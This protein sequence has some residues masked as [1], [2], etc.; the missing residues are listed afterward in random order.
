VRGLFFIRVRISSRSSVTLHNVKAAITDVV[1]TDNDFV[2]I[3]DPS[4]TLIEDV[5]DDIQLFTKERFKESLVGGPEYARPF[6][7]DA[8]TTKY[9][10]IAQ[11][12]C[13]MGVPTFLHMHDTQ[14]IKITA[15]EGV[16]FNCRLSGAGPRIN[17]TVLYQ[18]M[19]KER[20]R[21]SL[22]DRTGIVIAI[23]EGLG[24]ELR[25]AS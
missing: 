24:N 17:F 22:Q 11:L 7:L 6:D 20:F 10:E 23:K 1:S 8:E 3:N 5:D 15:V 19:E 2:E 25:K 13:L 14:K 4:V 16:Q 9:L 21:V 12:E 18:S